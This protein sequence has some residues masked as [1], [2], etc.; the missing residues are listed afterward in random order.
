[1]DAFEYLFL[2]KNRKLSQDLVYNLAH[3]KFTKTGN[4]DNL[5]FC[6]RCYK[7]INRLK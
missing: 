6:G 4:F 5:S 1:M 3:A 2:L 7:E